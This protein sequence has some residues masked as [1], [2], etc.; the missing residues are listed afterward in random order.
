MKFLFRAD[1]GHPIGTGHLFRVRRI[2]DKLIARGHECH[3][4]TGQNSTAEHIFA[5]TSVHMH[6]IPPIDYTG[7]AK[8]EFKSAAI[9]P[10]IRS[11]HYDALI[12]DMLDTDYDDMSCVRDSNFPIVTFDDRGSGRTC[13]KAIINVLVRE[14]NRDHLESSTQLYEGGSY[15]TLSDDFSSPANMTR[16][17]A[18]TPTRI[19]VVMGGADAAGLTVKCAKALGLVNSI[20][21]VEFMAGPAFVHNDDLQRVLGSVHYKFEVLNMLP[22]LQPAYERNDICLVAGG[23]AMY[24][25]CRV[26][27]PSVAIPQSIDHQFELAEIL[28]A[29]GA[30]LTVGW[31]ERASTIDI[32]NC[33]QRLIIDKDL[34][35]AMSD[36]GQRLVDGLGSNRV[37]QIIEETAEGY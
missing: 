23:L 35:M 5:D 31:G 7:R 37:A 33:V 10:L 34:R 6:W 12:I 14:Q 29:E 9:L 28:C 17:F 16:S 36:N 32:A 25:V 11:D 21:Q 8:P 20:E 27:I 22:S 3:L 18:K 26:G 4:V 15:V 19:F 13:A 1:G 2:V 24:E 30:M